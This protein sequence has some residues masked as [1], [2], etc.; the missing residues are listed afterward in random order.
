MKA[1]APFLLENFD[2]I[3]VTNAYEVLDP[4]FLD[5]LIREAD[6]SE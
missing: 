5:Q 2:C 1:P 3:H 6:K 4:K